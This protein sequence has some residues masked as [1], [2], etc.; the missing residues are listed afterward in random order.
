MI[1]TILLTLIL[2]FIVLVLIEHVVFPLF[3][4]F[5]DRKG[6]SV[7]GIPGM[8]GKVGEVKQC[9]NNE[10]RIFVHGELRR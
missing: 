2:G 7:C 1:K 8:L 4:F 10:R 9:Q 5:K 6:K 3:L